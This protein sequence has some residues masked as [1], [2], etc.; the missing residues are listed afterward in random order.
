VPDRFGF[1][2]EVYRG[3]IYNRCIECEWPGWGVILSEAARA[4]HHQHHVRERSKAA[5]KQ[6]KANLA[7]ARKALKQ[8]RQE[9]G[10]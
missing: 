3:A 2:H 1:T 7:K 8:N 5:A 4:R 9:G 6:Q 10:A